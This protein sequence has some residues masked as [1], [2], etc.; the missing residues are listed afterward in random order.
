MMSDMFFGTD[1]DGKQSI[2]FFGWK[3]VIQEN[4]NIIICRILILFLS[5]CCLRDN[6]D[7]TSHNGIR[8]YP[9]GME[10]FSYRLHM[11][12]SVASASVLASTTPVGPCATASAI[13]TVADSY[14]ENVLDCILLI[15]IGNRQFH[16]T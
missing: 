8:L 4:S 6:H 3:E 14:F 13:L 10:R 15:N 7:P 2:T 12:I 5:F 1:C 16:F 9:S 11:P